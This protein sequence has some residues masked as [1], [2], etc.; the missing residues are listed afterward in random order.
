MISIKAAFPS[1]ILFIFRTSSCNVA[2]LA[3]SG[4]KYLFFAKVIS[5]IIITGIL[6]G[7]LSLI[8]FEI[9]V[10]KLNSSNKVFK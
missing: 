4:T 6:P 9:S 8:F 5:E 2:T 7:N 1:A 10:I 3:F